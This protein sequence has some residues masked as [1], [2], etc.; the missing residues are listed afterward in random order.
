MPRFFTI[1]D[2]NVNEN[3]ESFTIVAE[4]GPDVPDNIVCFRSPVSIDWY[5]R[6]GATIRI[7]DNDRKFHFFICTCFDLYILLGVI[8]VKCHNA[9]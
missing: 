4:I 9:E 5:R 3:E 2:D 7:F 6:G 1:E 8:H